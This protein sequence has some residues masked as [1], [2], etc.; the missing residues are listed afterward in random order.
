MA[1][2]CVLMVSLQRAQRWRLNTISKGGSQMV[3][4]DKMRK[5][6]NP[7]LGR[8]KIWA[9]DIR[10]AEAR[11]GIELSEWEEEFMDVVE[12]ALAENRT[13]SPAQQDKLEDIW[14]RV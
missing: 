11:G 14:G 7:V 5:R 8:A 1:L 12:D 2:I 6:R 10:A 4:M 9:A 3:D 13:L